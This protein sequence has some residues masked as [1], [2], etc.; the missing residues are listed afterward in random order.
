MD[1]PVAS[2]RFYILEYTYFIL[3]VLHLNDVPT[4]PFVATIG[5]IFQRFRS[6]DDVAKP[7]F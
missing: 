6:D 7:L 1:C 2:S 5:A 3:D 4:Y